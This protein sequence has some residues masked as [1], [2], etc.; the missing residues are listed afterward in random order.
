MKIIITETQVNTFWQKVKITTPDECWIYTGAVNKAGYGSLTIGSR[1]DRTRQ[2]IGAHRLSYFLERGEIPDGLVIHHDCRNTSCVNPNHL[3][4]VTQSTNVKLRV[5]WVSPH[6]HKTHCP[7]GHEYTDANTRMYK[8]RRNC[9][10]CNRVSCKAYY[11]K[12]KLENQ[13][14]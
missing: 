6:A 8:G 7:S 11:Y 14:V 2:A 5:G 12:R 13:N 4:A 9:R 10:K 3:E 1:T